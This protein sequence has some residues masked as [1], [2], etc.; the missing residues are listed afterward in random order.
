[1]QKK[2]KI[3]V[4]NKHYFENY[5]DLKR[6]ISYFYQI[7]E[8]KQ[9]KPK[10]VLEVGIGNKTTSNYLKHNKIKVDTCD[11]DKTLKPDYVANIWNLPFKNDSYDVILACEILEHIPWQDINMTLKELHRVSKKYV[12]I[13]IPYHGANFEII[14]KFPLIN[15]LFKTP[16]ISLFFRI[17]HFFMKSKNK[18]EHYWEMGEKKYSKRKIKSTFKKYFKI[19]KEVRPI[20]NSYHHF[21][22]LAKK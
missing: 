22:I 20:L 8:V 7:N 14:L 10:N 9:L 17:P 2:Y 16:F 13:S 19:L 5:D 18:K 1:M 11:F 21:F 3:Q 4:P 12:I 6:W 15:T